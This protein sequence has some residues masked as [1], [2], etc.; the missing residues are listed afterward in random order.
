MK[1]YRYQ[2]DTS[3]E[4][5]IELFPIELIEF[6]TIKETEKGYWIEVLG[7]LKFVLKSQTGKRF[8]Y[9]TKEAALE[10]FKARTRRSI[11]IAKNMANISEEY[12]KKADEIIL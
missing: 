3:D 9:E 1:L 6:E 2:R 7:K 4:S 12:L 5:W 11:I 8:A 10:N